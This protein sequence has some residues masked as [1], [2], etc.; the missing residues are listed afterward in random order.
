MNLLLH[1]IFK[2]CTNKRL[3][4]KVK[5]ADLALMRVTPFPCNCKLTSLNFVKISVDRDSQDTVS[6]TPFDS[7][8]LCAATGV[9]T[10]FII[11]LSECTK[12]PK[13]SRTL[14]NPLVS[15]DQSIH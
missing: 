8:L 12:L 13:L 4:K 9:Q 15:F 3:Y 1:T 6:M 2:F 14:L 7:H 5:V 11:I 10:L